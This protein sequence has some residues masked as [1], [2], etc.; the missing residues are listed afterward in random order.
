MIFYYKTSV[1]DYFINDRMGQQRKLLGR[2]RER[3][4]KYFGHVTRHNSLEK[5]VMLG[6]MPGLRRQGGQRRQWLDDLYDWTDLSLTQLVRAAEERI[7]YRSMVHI[8]SYARLA[9]T[10]H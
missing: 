4:L 6:P 8:V 9:G 1:V 10:V 3:K 5:D 7:S 2:I